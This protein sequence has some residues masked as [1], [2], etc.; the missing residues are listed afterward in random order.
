MPATDGTPRPSGFR[1][2]TV[3]ARDSEMSSIVNSSGT[4]GGGVAGRL[5]ATAP[6]PEGTGAAS[7]DE[8]S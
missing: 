7:Y 1:R 4:P 8:T 5:N 2:S 6:D 3:R